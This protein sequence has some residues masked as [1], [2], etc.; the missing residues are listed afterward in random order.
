MRR[1]AFAEQILAM[2]PASRRN[3]QH[4]FC[5]SYQQISALTAEKKISDKK[6]F[7][8]NGSSLMSSQHLRGA[9]A[10]RCWAVGKPRNAGR[11]KAIITRERRVGSALALQLAG[12]TATHS[13]SLFSSSE[14]Y[15]PADCL[16]SKYFNCI[17]LPS[18][19]RVISPASPQTRNFNYKP[20]AGW[21]DWNLSVLRKMNTNSHYFPN[22]LNRHLL[23]KEYYQDHFC[24]D[25]SVLRK[26]YICF[27]LEL[28][29]PHR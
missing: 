3:A 18:R 6:R 27:F 12:S 19:C 24:C 23:G 5:C 14:E 22:Q 11:N 10:S 21:E 25:G 1:S 26:M 9:K 28:L 15:R 4:P 29:I 2:G 20:G 13:G 16:R 17:F 7:W 8:T